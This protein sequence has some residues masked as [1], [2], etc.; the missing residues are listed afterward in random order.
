MFLLRRISFIK[1]TKEV[2]AVVRGIMEGVKNTLRK[3]FIKSII[4]IFLIWGLVFLGLMQFNLPYNLYLQQSESPWYPISAETYPE[5]GVS[6]IDFAD[7][8]HGWI[9]GKKGLL[10]ATSD[11]GQVWQEQQSG[12]NTTIKAIDFFNATIGVA[13]S[14]T[15]EILITHTGGETWNLL[16]KVKNPNPAVGI[17]L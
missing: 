5:Y 10:M 13:I 3:G 16:E 2:Q 14:E 17:S 12:I 1:S 9:G 15:D 8:Y 7:S 4:V 6:A 11:G